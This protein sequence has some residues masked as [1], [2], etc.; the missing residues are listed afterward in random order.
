MKDDS[1]TNDNS[2]AGWRV[3]VP[4]VY[5][6]APPPRSAPV[7]ITADVGVPPQLRNREALV[8]FILGIVGLVL[9]AGRIFGVPVLAALFLVCGFPLTIIGI[10]VS[11]VGCR[12]QVR[13]SKALWGLLF[14]CVG[15]I[16]FIVFNLIVHPTRSEVQGSGTII[17]IVVLIIEGSAIGGCG[18][19]LL[20]GAIVVW[21]GDLRMLWRGV[22][23][24]GSITDRR[25]ETTYSGRGGRIVSYYVT[26]DYRYAG[27]TYSHKQRVGKRQY[28]RLDRGNRV[29]VRCLSR[30]PKVA[31]LAKQRS[32]LIEIASGLVLFLL[33]AGMLSL[34]IFLVILTLR[35][36]PWGS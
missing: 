27:E 1:S 7:E 28:Q 21:W 33:G 5:P 26:Y 15:F 23:V 9:C 13:R 3:Y 35:T 12:L 2:S 16:L 4:G 31:L 18:L 34:S 22:T 24:E 11:A 36:Y 19:L 14:S 6:S 10:V 32:D 8:G 29:A 17:G 20:Y 30:R 25:T